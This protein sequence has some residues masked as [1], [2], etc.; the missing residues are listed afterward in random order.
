MYQGMFLDA[1]MYGDGLWAH[2]AVEAFTR[3]DEE[4]I[5]LI[6][7]GDY[8]MAGKSMQGSY[9]TLYHCLNWMLCRGLL[10]KTPTIYLSEIKDRMGTVIKECSTPEPDTGKIG[11]LMEEIS[12]RRSVFEITA[13]SVLKECETVHQ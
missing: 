11:D 4:V 9:T 6:E 12:D 7:D 1:M 3:L 10:A 13:D 2:Y 8:K 5:P